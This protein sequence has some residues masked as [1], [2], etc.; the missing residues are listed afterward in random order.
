[1]RRC[2]KSKQNPEE[3]AAKTNQLAVLQRL[4]DC[5]YLKIYFMDQSGFSL[6]P[7]IPYGWQ[8]KD[9]L[10]RLPSSHSKRFNVLGFMSKDNELITFTTEKSIN[11]AFTIQ[12]MDDFCA[13]RKEPCVVVLDNAPIHKSNAFKLKI[14]EWEK[15]GMRV[16]FLPPYSPHLNKIEILWRK[17]KYEWINYNAY[18]SFDNLK[19]EV[20]NIFSDFGTKYT[21]HFA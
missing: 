2:L 12:A 1:M 7:P 21:I 17:I 19:N 6:I 18:L 20:N 16:F 4:E 8:L 3:V 10:I 9:E 15:K 13:S 5:N 14:D 11:S